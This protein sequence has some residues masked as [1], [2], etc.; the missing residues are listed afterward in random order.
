MNL[1]EIS[2]KFPTELSAVEYFEKVRWD[3][4][5]TC[6]YCGS[7]NIGNRNKD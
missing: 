5:I 3:K 6:P 2:N 4:D 7:T 1:I